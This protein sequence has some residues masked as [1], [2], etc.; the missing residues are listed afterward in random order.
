M[1]IFQTFL[2]SSAGSTQDILQS[3]SLAYLLYK[4]NPMICFLLLVRKQLAQM[5]LPCS[6]FVSMNH[7]IHCHATE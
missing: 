1:H 6:E 5:P 4:M 3:T 7:G 2:G